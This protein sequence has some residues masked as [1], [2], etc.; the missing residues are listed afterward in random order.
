MGTPFTDVYGLALVTINDYKINN[1]AVSN[2][3]G[4][5]MLC[6]GYLM[7]AIPTFYGCLTDLSFNMTDKEFDNELSIQEINILADLMSIQWF[8]SKIQNVTQFDKKLPTRDFKILGEESNLK[9]KTAYLDILTERVKKSVSD[10]QLA[11]GKIF[12]SL[13]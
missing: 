6:E 8:L 12:S 11:F 13:S 3:T 1:L 5:N 9:A 2:P 10:Y 7:R 4:F